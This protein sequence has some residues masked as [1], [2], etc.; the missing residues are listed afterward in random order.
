[1]RCLAAMSEV[2]PV[3]TQARLEQFDAVAERYDV[4]RD[5]RGDELV[6]SFIRD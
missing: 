3:A 1:M 6:N 2:D 4:F 5:E